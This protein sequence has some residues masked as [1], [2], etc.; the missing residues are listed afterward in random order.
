[1]PALLTRMSTRPNASSAAL[2]ILSPLPGSL[3]DNVEAMAWPPAFLISSTTSC[4]GPAS[5]PAPSRLA[6]ISQTTTLA[7]SWAMSSAMPRPMPRAAPVTMA[8]LPATM[9]AV[10]LFS[11]HLLGDFADHPQ[12]RPLFLFGESIPFLGRGEAAL[13]REAEL[14]EI[15]K[16]G[17]FLDA[18]L[19][20]VLGFQRADL[21]R[22]QAEHHEA[23]FLQALERLETAG[24]VGVVFHEI[25][26]HLDLVEQ[27]FLLGLVAAGAH[28]GR[29]VVAAAQM[30]GHRHVRRNVGHRDVDE[31]A[32]ERTER[33][34]IVAA[35]LHLLAI[36]RIAEH[37]DE[38]F[39]E[40][41]VAAAG[42]GESAYGFFVGLAEIVEHRVELGIDRLVDRCADRAAVQRRRRRDRYLWR[43]LGVRLDEFEMLDHRM[44]GEADLAGDLGAFV[45][46]PRRG[47]RDA[48]LHDGLLDTVEAPEE[49][50]VP[51][52]AAEFAV[53]DRLQAGR[54]LLPDDVLDLAVFPRS[55]LI[56]R[57]LALGAALARRFQRRG[58]QQAAD[59]IGAERRF[60][61]L[62]GGLS[63]FLTFLPLKG[64]GRER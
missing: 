50:E 42:I 35:I 3:I 47:K 43:T 44:A 64:G 55:Q 40:L 27:H 31:L 28:E 30:H 13:R 53:G 34:G 29:F 46:R 37:G 57:D 11:P 12:L 5:V 14:L 38:C 45:A 56:R 2:T 54:L 22:H 17:G 23:I 59:M 51:P 10:G 61:S 32:V 49:I 60:G 7:P 58:P 16:F 8:T 6:P 24:A 21:C 48:G 39:V 20:G 62:H 36:L 26:V 25:A 1:M 19:D 52:R 33:F 4:A 18:A 63:Y 41:Q 9:F 15:G